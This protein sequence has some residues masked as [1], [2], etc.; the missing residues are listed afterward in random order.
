MTING[1][2][3][4]TIRLNTKTYEKIKKIAEKR[5]WKISPTIEYLLEEVCKQEDVGL[6]E[7]DVLII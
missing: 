3:Q 7:S 1:K 4:V 6:L 2:I 5:K